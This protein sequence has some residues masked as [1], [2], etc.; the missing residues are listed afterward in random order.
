MKSFVT[1]IHHDGSSRYVVA[2]A[3][4]SVGK[5]VTLRLRTGLDVKVRRVFLRTAPDGEE[6]FD[7]MALEQTGSACQWWSIQVPLLMPVVVYR[8]LLLTEQ[9]MLWY[10]AAGVQ[11]DTPTDG[12]DFQ[13]L[14]EY[15]APDWLDGRVFYQIFP[16]RFC[17]GDPT[18]N[19]GDGAFVYRGEPSRARKWGEASQ[20]TGRGRS[21]EFYGGD[22]MGV[23]QKLP[24]LLDLGINGI[25]LTPIFPAFS[26]HRYD[27]TDYE[28]VD[29][30]LGGD[31][32]FVSL[33]ERTRAMDVRLMLD[34]VPN[35]CGVMHPWFQAALQDFH[36]E[37]AEFFT[38]FSHPD[39]YACWL[40]VR[41]LP[42]LNY[43]SQKLREWM[44]AGADAIFRRWLR[45][46]FAIDA[47][48][49]DVANML[50]RQ[51]EMQLGMEVG[52]GIRAAVKAENPQAYLLGENFFD[53]SPQLQGDFLDACM[54]YAGFARPLWHWLS[55]ASIWV[56]E[57]REVVRS[58]GAISTEAMVQTWV[59]FLAAIPWQIAQQQFNLL[60]SHDTP[61]IRTV[62]KDDEQRVRMAAALL[63]TYP[64]VPCIYYGDEIG[65]SS[66]DGENRACMIWNE[67][68]WNV[69]LRAYFQ[70]LIALR[71]DSAALR[72]GGF[73]I[74]EVETDGLAYLRDVEE[75]EMI[76]VVWRGPLP[77]PVGG[78]A[79]WRGG[80]AD[81]S[82]W[83]NVLTGQRT[84]VQNGALLLP[85]MATG[86]MIWRK[87]E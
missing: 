74:L 22:L 77:R 86:A 10:N 39:D 64:G 56:L 83:E 6:R 21:L 50:A 78:M 85:E 26:N 40:G 19:I 33:R 80:V 54:N 87:V 53:A 47:W 84:M 16:D 38:F 71:K 68:N 34:I 32:A 30:S 46:P 3:G 1:S 35:H 48:R 67:E 81:G 52:R 36:A 75:E 69:E 57:Q 7:E 15:R 55:G 42:K 45:P 25:Y 73:Q 58:G 17:D 72:H 44:Y 5:T 59:N 13:L 37:T 70:R 76:V 66:A 60:G 61:R 8:F 82:V 43:G 2:G 49:I 28:H 11:D 20:V 65:M 79:V 4:L 23:E 29:G 9:G 51:G 14:A 41:S 62:V 24:Y 63:L 18:N 12:Q 27:V 31:E